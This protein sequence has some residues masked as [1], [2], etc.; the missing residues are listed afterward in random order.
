MA[1]VVSIERF[2]ARHKIIWP[3]LIGASAATGVLWWNLTGT[4][5]DPRNGETTTASALLQQFEWSARTTWA[6]IGIIACVILR[7]VGYIIRLKVLSLGSFSWKQ[8]FQNIVL[9]EFA[10]ALTPS[11]V[12]GSAVAIVLLKRDGLNWG[13]SVATVF[14]TALMDEVF[15]LIAVP[16][17]WLLSSQFNHAFFPTGVSSI[18]TIFWTAYAF[19]A[20]LTTI[21]LWGIFIAPK[22]THH[23][24]N[25]LAHRP[26]FSRWKLHLEEWASNLLTASQSLRHA[27]PSLWFK[28]MGSTAI[29]WTARFLTLN[30]I[31]LLFYEHVPHAAVMTRQLVLWIAMTISPTPGSSGVAELA[32]PVFLGDVMSL[33]YIAAVVMVWRLA[34]YFLYLIIGTWVL[35]SWIARTQRNLHAKSVK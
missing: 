14:A 28:A 33:A 17:T 1:K 10:S 25:K 19:I 15:Y 20:L 11:V 21:I 2:F 18:G 16:I 30:M 23:I 7:D 24:L 26:W 35:P 27:K 4:V 6:T 12:G 31:L 8:A 22:R 9:W 5:I 29:S 34:T 32:L 3:I 13:K